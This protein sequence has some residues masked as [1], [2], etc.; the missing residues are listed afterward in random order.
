MENV[1]LSEAEVHPIDG[2]ESEFLGVDG[3][4]FMKSGIDIEKYVRVDGITFSPI[5]ERMLAPDDLRDPVEKERRH[6]IWRAKYVRRIPKPQP[7]PRQVAY[8]QL[9][10]DESKGNILSWIYVK[11]LKCLAIKRESGMQYLNSILRILVLPHYDVSALARIK[12]IN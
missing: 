12:M 11:D 3:I 6:A 9:E 7:P 2:D 10:N 8:M 4:D 5:Y 1:N